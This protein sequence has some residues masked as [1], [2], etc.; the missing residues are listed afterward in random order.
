VVELSQKQLAAAF[1]IKLRPA[2]LRP[3]EGAHGGVGALGSVGALERVG[4]LGKVSASGSISVLGSV[5]TFGSQWLQ[6]VESEATMASFGALKSRHGTLKKKD[7]IC[8]V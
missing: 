6:V 7:A 4:A 5:G 8:I 3:K 2:E 1:I